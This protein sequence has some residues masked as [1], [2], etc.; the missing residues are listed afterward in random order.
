MSKSALICT[1]HIMCLII[2]GSRRSL[3][4]SVK[5][6]AP[7]MKAQIRLKGILQEPI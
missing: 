2:S 7:P 5:I 3:S 4:D 1:M 6:L